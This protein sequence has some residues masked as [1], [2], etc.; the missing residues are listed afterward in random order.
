VCVC[1]CVCVCVS[2]SVMSG[3]VGCPHPGA[4]GLLML[5]GNYLSWPTPACVSSSITIT[6]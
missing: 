3:R 4:D 2:L 6:I 5:N 1:V